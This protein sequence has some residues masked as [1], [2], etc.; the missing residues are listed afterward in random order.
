MSNYQ[1]N[2]NSLLSLPWKNIGYYSASGKVIVRSKAANF[3]GH[4]VK[5]LNKIIW[6][7]DIELELDL[8]EVGDNSSEML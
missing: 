5:V 1:F 3:P 8:L 2:T 6:T 4:S 7:T